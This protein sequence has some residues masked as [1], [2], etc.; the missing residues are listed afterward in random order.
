MRPLYKHVLIFSA[1]QSDKT[2]DTNRDSH[3]ALL[4]ALKA[5]AVPFKEV[6]GSYNHIREVSVIV[7]ISALNLVKDA[8][9]RFNQESYLERFSDNTAQLV[10][11]GNGVKYYLGEIKATTETEAIATGNFTYDTETN[12]YFTTQK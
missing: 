9:Y 12:T 5:A 6:L 1:Y 4:G 10:F 8:C 7:P 2:D 11:T 3:Q